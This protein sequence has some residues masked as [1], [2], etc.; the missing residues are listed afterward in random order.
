VADN[1]AIT[2]GSGTSIA[3]DDISSVHY[4]RIKRSV[5]ADGSAT[6]YLDKSSRSDTYTAAANGTTV[7]VSA[8]GMKR[9]GLQVKQTG[10]VSSWTVLLEVSLDGTN[11]VTVLTHTKADDGDGAIAFTGANLYPALYFRSRCSAI[12]LGGGTNVIATIVGMP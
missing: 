11:F 9:F 7:D 1:V 6:D 3:T 8:Q 12:T 4:Q 5:G 2:A 10:T